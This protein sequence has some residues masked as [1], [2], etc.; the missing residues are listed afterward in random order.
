MYKNFLAGVYELVEPHYQETHR[1]FHSIKHINIGIYHL[2]KLE[3]LGA[4][5]TDTQKA[6]WLFHDIVY[7]LD[8][9][10]NE[11][12]SAELFK[13]Y[14]LQ[15]DLGFDEDE[16]NEIMQII[17]D[18]KTH[19]AT[20]NAS[21]IILDVDMFVLAS[22]P[23][24]F[25]EYREDIKKE[26]SSKFSSQEIDQGTLFFIESLLNQPEPI[27]QSEHFLG[28]EKFAVDNLKMYQERLLQQK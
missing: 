8:R 13:A 20:I 9:N 23:E 11:E 28:F 6:A 2:T 21:K 16:V 5:I 7:E 19:K 25:I 1:V 18:T 15:Y 3:S 24:T 10:D 14:N 12:K 17:V 4:I 26:Y 27:F 22:S